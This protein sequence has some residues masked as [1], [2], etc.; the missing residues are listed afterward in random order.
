MNSSRKG[1]CNFP[2]L[3]YVHRV[4]NPQQTAGGNFFCNY[5]IN[6]KSLAMPLNSLE[7]MS[8]KACRYINAYD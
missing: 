4:E 7:K 8:P 1:F 2:K 3:Q 6:K 5:L